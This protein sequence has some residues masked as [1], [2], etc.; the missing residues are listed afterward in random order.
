[1]RLAVLSRLLEQGV[2]FIP[3]LMIASA[4][5]GLG[6]LVSGAAAAAMLKALREEDVPRAGLLARFTRL[7]LMVFFFAMALNEIGIAR[8]IVVVGFSAI[9][10]T[11]C[12]AVLIL[13]WMSG[14][15]GAA[16]ILGFR[17]ST[18]DGDDGT[19]SR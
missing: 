15:Q 7:L 13:L 14:P 6:W 5:I 4:I 16:R 9:I 12:L 19:D 17:E 2:S 10:I 18:E 8:D 11:L 3:K 1:M